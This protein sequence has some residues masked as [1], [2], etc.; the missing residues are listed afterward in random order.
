MSFFNNLKSLVP[1]TQKHRSDTL[2]T[3]LAQSK[4]TPVPIVE[5]TKLVIQ[6]AA[7]L[8]N[9]CEVEKTKRSTI[10]AQRDV[11]I[12][13]IDA[14]KEIILK[15]MAFAFSER[16]A[17]L[18]KNFDILDVAIQNNDYN[19]LNLALGTIVQ[20]VQTSPFHEI[21]EIVEGKGVLRFE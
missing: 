5:A 12:A 13:N 17:V 1:Y 8:I 18:T 20:V 21:Q 14:Q 7:D 9:T 6:S 3:S 4:T 10:A 19:M 11:A 2:I 15:Y 16:A